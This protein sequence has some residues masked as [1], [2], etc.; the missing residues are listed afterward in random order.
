VTCLDRTSGFQ[1]QEKTNADGE[2]AF[3]VRDWPILRGK[4]IQ[5]TISTVDKEHKFPTKTVEVPGDF[6]AGLAGKGR[7]LVGHEGPAREDAKLG[8]GYLTHYL[9]EGIGGPADANKDGKVSIREAVEYASQQIKRQT[10]SGLWM[11]GEGDLDL[12][13]SVPKP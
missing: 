7:W 10:G 2:A 5:V 1:T 13:T 6:F 9:L 11:Q 3:D 4:P 12:V 8:H